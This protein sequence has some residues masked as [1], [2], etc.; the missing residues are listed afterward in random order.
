MTK[1]PPAVDQAGVNGWLDI[2]ER[3]NATIVTGPIPRITPARAA[4]GHRRGKIDQRKFQ[5][6]PAAVPASIPAADQRRWSSQ[7]RT[8][9][10]EG[11]ISMKITGFSFEKYASETIS[12]DWRDGLNGGTG[13]TKVELLLRV[14]KKR[15]RFLVDQQFPLRHRGYAGLSGQYALWLTIPS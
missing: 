8:Q 9:A 3:K 13:G 12:Y 7:Q 6:Q 4:T 5:P 14:H 1:S 11:S 10:E 2:C 15:I